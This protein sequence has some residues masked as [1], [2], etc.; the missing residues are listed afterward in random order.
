[1]LG[2]PYADLP[3]KE[4]GPVDLDACAELAA[5]FRAEIERIVTAGVPYRPDGAVAR[6]AASARRRARTRRH[7]SR[8]SVGTEGEP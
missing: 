2:S 5:Y 1:M 3:R 7:P 4:G 8:T 6:T